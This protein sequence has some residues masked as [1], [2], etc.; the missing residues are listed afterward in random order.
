MT[1]I[2]CNQKVISGE[3]CTAQVMTA[4]NTGLKIHAHCHP[5]DLDE[6]EVFEVILSN[7]ALVKRLVDLAFESERMKK[8]LA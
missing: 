7:G 4:T 5:N 2:Y 8:F 6:K 1:Q 3:A